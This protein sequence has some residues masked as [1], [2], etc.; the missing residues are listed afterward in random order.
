MSLCM[1]CF[2]K[3]RIWEYRRRLCQECQEQQKLDRNVDERKTP[4]EV[5][6][7]R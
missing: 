3:L 6:A 2:E 1:R 5:E 7:T 4:V